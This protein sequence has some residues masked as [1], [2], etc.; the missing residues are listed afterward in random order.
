MRPQ[1]LTQFATTLVEHLHPS[2]EPTALVDSEG[3]FEAAKEALA[4]MKKV[5][6]EKQDQEN[7]L[8]LQDGASPVEEAEVPIQARRL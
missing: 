1:P 3:T 2:V 7:A 6:E 8:A 4:A 5:K